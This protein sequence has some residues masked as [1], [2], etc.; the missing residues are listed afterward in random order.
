MTHP[1]HPTLVASPQVSFDELTRQL[2]ELG[3]DLEQS[4]TEPIVAGEP[5]LGV[6]VHRLDTTAIHYTF[7]PVVNLRVLQFRGSN[8]QSQRLQVRDRI[9]VLGG[10]ELHA[11]LDSGETKQMLLGL[12][13][14]EELSEMGV[15]QQVARL[16]QHPDSRI[17]RTAVRVRDSLLPATVGEIANQ[18]AVEQNQHP[19][20]SVWFASL[21]Q[22]ELRKQVLRW[23]MRD[24]QSSNQGIDRVLVSALKDPD[25][26]VRVTAVLAAAK[27]KATSLMPAIRDAN[28]PKS[29][30][31][32]A[33]ERDRLFYER[34]RQT[35]AG[36]LALSASPAQQKPDEKRLQFEKAV[37][38]T[39]EVRDA[40]TLL[41][42]A[43][44]TP[45]Q[46]GEKP[47][48][49]PDAVEERGD[50]YCL[51][52][53]G[54]RLRWVAPIAHW[55]G[56]DSSPVPPPRSPIRR[57]I[58]RSGLFIAETP[59][60]SE[61]ALWTSEAKERPAHCV[62]AETHAFLCG[63]DE[64]M[65]LCDLLGQLDGIEL[66]LPTADQWE[67]A[68]RGPDGRRYPWGNSL[69][70][71]GP[72]QPSP[73]LVKNM[74]GHASEWTCDHGDQGARLV[75]GGNLLACAGREVVR[76]D[77]RA[78]RCAVR[79]VLNWAGD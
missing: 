52:K 69:R 9:P 4:S 21:P 8:A 40:P 64:A 37:S 15:V 54:L 42:Y 23:L 26:E 61:L 13:A 58:P 17:A 5:E 35:A 75:C 50:G 71:D 14:A 41:L 74:V 7:N 56:E 70:P 3:W 31:L 60:S 65:H 66:K 73:W 38:G 29:T 48:R 39:L 72:L 33:D 51:R 49:L 36:Y 44:T 25:P 78:V 1:P 16:C 63:Y 67:I 24:S 19:E 79:P 62:P 34:L 27:L 18:L 28:I 32:G 77:D 53:S 30:S 45:V 57:V 59:V 11:L 68:A 10:K 6:F 46:L 47:G 22:P 43:L 12:L 2:T 55:L 20:R 76:G